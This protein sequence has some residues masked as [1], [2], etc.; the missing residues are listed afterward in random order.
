M[1]SIEDDIM[2]EPEEKDGFCPLCKA[3]VRLIFWNGSYYT[4][5]PSDPEHKFRIERRERLR[6][7]PSAPSR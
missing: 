5:C 3:I 6:I 2:T 1:E 4:Q 7:M